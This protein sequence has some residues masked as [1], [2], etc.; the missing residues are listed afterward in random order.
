M[1]DGA[2]GWAIHRQMDS[3]GYLLECC[4]Q[5]GLLCAALQ[6]EEAQIRAEQE[7]QKRQSGPCVPLPCTVHQRSFPCDARSDGERLAQAAARCKQH[8]ACFTPA[9]YGERRWHLHSSAHWTQGAKCV[10]GDHLQG[11]RLIE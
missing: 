10:P 7:R 11:I 5:A 2:Q 4:P 9:A 6:V 3:M 8:A 1:C